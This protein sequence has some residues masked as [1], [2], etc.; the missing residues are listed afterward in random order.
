[1]MLESVPFGCSIGIPIPLGYTLHTEVESWPL[2]QAFALED[3]VCSTGF[4]TQKYNVVDITEYLDLIFQTLDTPHVDYAIRTMKNSVLPHVEQAISVVDAH[5]ADQRSRLT[6]EDMLGPLDMLFEFGELQCANE[7]DP[8]LRPVILIGPQTALLGACHRGQMLPYEEGQ[9]RSTDPALAGLGP[10]WLASRI[11]SNTSHFIS[12]ACEPSTGMRWCRTYILQRGKRLSYVRDADALVQRAYDEVPW[13]ALQ[14]NSAIIQRIESLNAKLVY[15]L[16]ACIKS[17]FSVHSDVL[18]A[19][20]AVQLTIDRMMK[21]SDP[22]TSDEIADGV[23]PVLLPLALR[24]V[25]L[26]GQEYLQVHM[27]CVNAHGSVVTIED[28]DDLG[29]TC[30]T[31]IR[32]SVHRVGSGIKDSHGNASDVGVVA[33]GDTF[34]FS[35]YSHCHSLRDIQDT[36]NTQNSVTARTARTSRT[37]GKSLYATDL[38]ALAIDNFCLTALLPYFRTFTGCGTEDKTAKA[39]SSSLKSPHLV[40]AL[41]LGKTVTESSDSGSE[42]RPA[43][44]IPILTD[45]FLVPYGRCSIKA[46]TG[47]FVIDK[48]NTQCLPLL[49]SLETH[50]EC[51][52]SADIK[53]AI[54]QVN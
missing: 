23:L 31:Y 34:L 51:M 54:L 46:F 16:R 26:M 27:D 24:N 17:A 45:H 48:I 20:Q 44:P 1:M 10:E 42:T 8:N 29:G 33:V 7:S 12:E 28:V 22:L 53:D 38:A 50:V 39:L 3:I 13:N 40:S 37:S 4:F 15:C 6:V 49:I 36:Q 21:S 2:L 18:D 9:V 32:V 41:G 5:T 11:G 14:S 19:G 43:D 25:L 47:G 30:W 52:W 35:S